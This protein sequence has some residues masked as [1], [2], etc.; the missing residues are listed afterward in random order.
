MQLSQEYL[1]SAFKEPLKE[2]ENLAI[3]QVKQVQH[4][5]S[6]ELQKTRV[7]SRVNYLIL[8]VAHAINTSSQHF[9]QT[10]ILEAQ[11]KTC[12]QLTLC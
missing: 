9:K 3:L 1:Y 5:I 7:I 4:K 12:K 11:T 10:K 8:Y 6:R 2:A